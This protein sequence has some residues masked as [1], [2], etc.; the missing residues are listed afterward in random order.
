MLGDQLH[1]IAAV[2]LVLLLTD[3][4]LALGVVLALGSIPQAIFSLLGGTIV[5]QFSPRRVMLFVDLARL[6]LSAAIAMTIFTGT[7][8]IWMIFVYALLTGVISGIFGPASSAIMPRIFPEKELQSGNLVFQGSAQL[9]GILGPILAAVF[10]AY[11]PDEYMG[12]AILIAVDSITFIASLIT[13]GLMSSGGEMGLTKGKINFKAVKN[14]TRAGSSYV[15]N[16]PTLRFL[17]VLIMVASFSFAGPVMVGI[18][19]LADTRFPEGVTAY[20]FIL[21]GYAA[22]NLLGIILSNRLPLRDKK[23]IHILFTAIFIAFGIGLAAMAWISTA[24]L[25]AIDLFI[26]GLLN[27]YISIFLLTGL[28]HNTPQEILGRLMSIVIFSNMLLMP[29]SQAIAGAVLRWNVESLFLGAAVL[30][31]GAAISIYLAGGR[32][33]IGDQLL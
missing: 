7:L 31:I 25:A 32:Y 29:F 4:P 3:D 30:M 22:G 13:L 9:I 1:N 11:F 23:G 16:N 21:S 33:K 8:K 27:G 12:I 28:Q 14:S 2:W 19:Y 20:G 6:V 5:D 24:R 17:F 26:M 15:S 10:I 18:P